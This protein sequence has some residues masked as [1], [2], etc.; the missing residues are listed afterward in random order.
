[1]LTFWNLLLLILN[2]PICYLGEMVC[3]SLNHVYRLSFFTISPPFQVELTA[4]L[5]FL[6]VPTVPP[7]EGDV[8][9]VFIVVQNLLASSFTHSLHVSIDTHERSLC[10]TVRCCVGLAI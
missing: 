9:Y 6:P 8:C 2:N 1:M 7:P 3:S 10:L 5:D 4:H